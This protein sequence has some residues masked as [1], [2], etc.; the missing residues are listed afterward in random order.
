[1][2]CKL[3]DIP[4]FL[5]RQPPAGLMVEIDCIYVWGFLPAWMCEISPVPPLV[6]IHK[7]SYIHVTSTYSYPH[8]VT[9]CVY[10]RMYICIYHVYTYIRMIYIYMDIHE[11]NFE[12]LVGYSFV[13]RMV[14][15]VYTYVY[16]HSR[17]AGSFFISIIR[18]RL[19]EITYIFGM[20][21]KQKY[22]LLY[23]MFSY[24]YTQYVYMY[25]YI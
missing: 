12:T 2:S 7:H 10:V 22:R 15:Q 25:K 4:L 6:H 19:H 16:I 24:M 17:M 14:I 13:V 3:I 5:V 8:H 1:M 21:W 20:A 23:N 11:I 18:R 9:W